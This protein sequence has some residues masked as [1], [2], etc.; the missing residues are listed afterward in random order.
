MKLRFWKRREEQPVSLPPL[1]SHVPDRRVA[2]VVLC[3]GSRA[4]LPWGIRCLRCDTH[5]NF[6]QVL[7]SVAY[8]QLLH[9]FTRSHMRCHPVATD[10]AA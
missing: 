5:L 1:G 6:P 2:W 8:L 10:E 9:D 3:D 4:D 7:N